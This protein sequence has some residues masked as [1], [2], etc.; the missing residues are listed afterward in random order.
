[1]ETIF[2]NLNTINQ[3]NNIDNNDSNNDT[4]I[5]SINNLSSLERNLE[6]SHIIKSA[7]IF[8]YQFEDNFIDELFKFSKIHQYDHRH[9]FKKE[10]EN[11]IME[12]KDLIDNEVIHLQNLGYDGDILDKM[13]K[14]ARYY[15]RKKNTSAKPHSIRKTY[16]CSNCNIIK[17]MED[18]IN[19]N[20]CINNFKPSEGFIDF[21]K[22][23]ANVIKEQISL[24]CNAGITNSNEI[25]LKIK[26]TY[27]NRYYSIKNKT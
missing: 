27:K 25:K 5:Y 4:K 15:Y 23:N 18:H 3:S 2:Q 20:I 24:L 10:W 1:M 8:R 26:K 22:L 16:I 7:N 17:F 14:S 13:F 21:C 19:A 6:Y 11:W 12:N 9:D